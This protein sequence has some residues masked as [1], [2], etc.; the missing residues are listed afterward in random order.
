MFEG[1]NCS[2]SVVEA[3][4]KGTPGG[5]MHTCMMYA[6]VFLY[7]FLIPQG[8]FLIESAALQLRRYAGES[9][10]A[11]VWSFACTRCLCMDPF[12][13]LSFFFFWGVGWGGV[14]RPKSGTLIRPLRD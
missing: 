7:T 6:F 1:N 11:A 4:E 3:G 10:F 13:F 9:G 8:V 12:F 14:S 2:E 5:A